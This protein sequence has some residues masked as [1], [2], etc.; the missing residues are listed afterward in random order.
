M[1]EQLTPDNVDLIQHIA[2]VL[3]DKLDNRDVITVRDP[4]YRTRIHPGWTGPISWE[5]A[6]AVVTALELT[7]ERRLDSWWAGSA[8]SVVRVVGPWRTAQKEEQ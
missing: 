7:E 6:E 8:H 1:A 4:A 5:L 3:Q 2:D